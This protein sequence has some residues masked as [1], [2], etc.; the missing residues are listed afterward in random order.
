MVPYNFTAPIETDRLWL[1]LMTVQDAPAV[2]AYQGR[3]DVCQY[4][5][6]GPRS[7]EQ[8]RQKLT[9]YARRTRLVQD[10]DF[11]QLAVEDR[12]SGL[13]VGE[14]Y[15]ALRS[16]EH[17]TAEIGWVFHPDHHGHGYA[18]EAARAM[19]AL[20]FEQVGLH[21]ILAELTPQNTASVRLCQRLGMREEAHFVQDMLVKGRWEDTGVYALLREEWIATRRAGAV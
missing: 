20:G 1:R 19:L 13:L 21:R 10:E 4:L 18:T 3:E 5:L 12:A 16:L 7:L 17:R 8:V 9:D 2:H 6:Y 11:L 15:F 14:I